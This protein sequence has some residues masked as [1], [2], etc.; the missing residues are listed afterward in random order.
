MLHEDVLLYTTA[1]ASLKSE[2]TTSKPALV[3]VETHHPMT[4]E[5]RLRVWEVEV[6]GAEWVKVRRQT[7]PFSNTFSRSDQPFLGR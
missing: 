7:A 4:L 3:T 6:P 2:G 5:D 1:V